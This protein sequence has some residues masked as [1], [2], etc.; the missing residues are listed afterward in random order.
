M[1]LSFSFYFGPLPKSP[2]HLKGM[3]GSIAWPLILTKTIIYQVNTLF[4][5]LVT[6]NLPELLSGTTI[7]P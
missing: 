5:L 6:K 2:A 3:P 7:I 4:K 1:T